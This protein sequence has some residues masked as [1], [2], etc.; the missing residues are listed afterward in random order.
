MKLFAGD[1]HGLILVSRTKSDLERVA[2][3]LKMKFQCPQVTV[4]PKDL[5]K[6]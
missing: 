2:E 1:K 3:E 4:I 5:S 6:S